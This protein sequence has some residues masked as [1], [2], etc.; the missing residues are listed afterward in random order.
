MR[1]LDIYSLL[2]LLGLNPIAR[3]NVINSVKLWIMFE[4]N[5][6]LRS[7]STSFYNFVLKIMLT[8]KH[9]NKKQNSHWFKT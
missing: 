5:I 1:L 9:L 7:I 8:V 6:F 4:V 2:S 3:Q